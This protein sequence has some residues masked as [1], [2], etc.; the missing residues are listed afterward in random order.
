V[1]VD[2]RPVVCF[3]D[4]LTEGW[5]AEPS[6]AY[7]ARLEASLGVPVVNAG[8][9]GD[10]AV[11]AWDRLESQVL[12]ADPRLVVVQFGGNEEAHG[13]ALDMTRGGLERIL[14]ALDARGIPTVLVGTRQGTYQENLD[15]VLG[16][17][18]RRHRSELVL[19]ALKG[20][21][22]DPRLRSDADHPNAR[23]YR[24]FA[25]RILPAVRRALEK[26]P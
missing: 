12:A 25:E 21:L 13:D 24:R 2:P 10:R 11:D 6:E 14:Q 22:D 26:G 19:D 3:G 8:W 1:K 9:R 23:G 7:P 18:A 16:E 17:L 15:E 5:G 4:S 20:I